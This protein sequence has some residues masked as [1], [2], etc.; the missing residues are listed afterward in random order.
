MGISDDIKPKKY[1]RP[2]SQTEKLLIVEQQI[3][4]EKEK[5]ANDLFEDQKES[6]FF[7]GTPIGKRS[8]KQRKEPRKPEKEAEV[9]KKT[10]RSRSVPILIFIVFVLTGFLIWQNFS[11]LKNYLDF[12]FKIENDQ[13]LSEIIESTTPNETSYTS[14]QSQNTQTATPAQPVEITIDNSN[15]NISVLN[16]S[17][18]KNSAK[19]AADKLTT[20]GFTIKYTG[21]ARVF[22]YQKT[23]IYHKTGGEEKANLVKENL[24]DYDCEVVLSEVI[25]GATYDIVVVIGKT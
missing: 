25:V 19:I 8:E 4:K 24:I 15:I 11:K 3:E 20:A 1:R 14:E 22:T 18:V 13:K 12:K 17:G 21:N 10:K 5:V 23:Y 16:G 6:D 7:D 9:P 2:F